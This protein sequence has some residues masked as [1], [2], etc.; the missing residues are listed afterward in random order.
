VVGVVRWIAP[1]TC[2]FRA[3]N[4]HRLWSHRVVWVFLVTEECPSDHGGPS[5]DVRR[6]K[7]APS[8]RQSLTKCGERWWVHRRHYEG[9]AMADVAEASRV[10]RTCHAALSALSWRVV[11]SKGTAAS[12]GATVSDRRA[13]NTS[14]APR[15]TLTVACVATL[16]VLVNFTAPL[17]TIQIIGSQL[18]A[19]PSGQT[20][21]LGAISVG[22]AA[23]LLVAGSLAD[24]LGRKRVFLSGGALLVA[25]TV[26]CAMAPGTLVFVLSRVV[27]GGASAAILA[28]SLGLLGHV[29]PAGPE[30]VRAT[31]LWGAMVGGGIAIGPVY[32]VLLIKV[33]AWPIAYWVLAAI[34]ALITLWAAVALTESRS[35]HR[36]RL[37]LPGVISLGSGIGLLVAA[38]TESRGG[39]GQAH[40]LIMLAASVLL[41]AVFVMVERRAAAPMLDLGL[42]RNPSFVA[43]TLGAFLI[44]VAVI[45]FTTYIPTE[46][47]RVLGLS[48]LA[49]AGILAIWSGLSFVAALRA[50]RMV[51]LFSGRPQ[52]AAGL[53]LCGIGE[54]ALIGIGEDSSWWRFVPGLALAGLGSGLANA[55]L[56]GLAVQSVPAHRTA[57]G[58]GANNAARYLGSSLGVALIASVVALAPVG[59]GPG[60]EFAG[61]MTYAA[62]I[63][64]VLA[65]VGA[66]VVMA[67][68]ERP[69]GGA[70]AVGE[71][72]GTS[73]M[74]EKT[75]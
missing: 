75:E 51:W 44:G 46:A 12:K 66:L 74:G 28:S 59:G 11:G 68:R 61:G 33:A 73:S 1:I 47:Q 4:A 57:M 2:D 41:V 14:T 45:G 38:F 10:V 29:F 69:R 55:A 17:S 15:V 42:L 34:T 37:D 25:A 65:I 72:G 3:A 60:A 23:S 71:Q 30:R 35:E 39:W 62:I 13:V 50:R 52:V 7:L 58:S 56:A 31:G 6:S 27:Q 36:R 49:S 8:R 48:P 70:E 32:S 63:S 21:I 5:Q 54:L 9:F 26:V 43:A 18:G 16:L 40:V 53:V 22:L 64:G 67:C 20:W 19:G 24:D